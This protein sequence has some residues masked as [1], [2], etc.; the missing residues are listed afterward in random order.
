MGFRIATARGTDVIAYLNASVNF[1]SLLTSKPKAWQTFF[2]IDKGFKN[3]FS[4]RFCYSACF[5]ERF[6][7]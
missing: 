5:A 7:E 1:D 4:T 2:T 3:F 6:K